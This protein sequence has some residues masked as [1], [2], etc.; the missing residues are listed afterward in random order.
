MAHRATPMLFA[1]GFASMGSTAGFGGFPDPGGRNG[2]V[3]SSGGGVRGGTSISEAARLGVAVTRF[4]PC[5]PF[6]LRARSN[7]ASGFP[8]FAFEPTLTYDDAHRRFSS[9][10]SLASATSSGAAKHVRE[11]LDSSSPRPCLCPFRGCFCMNAHTLLGPLFSS[12][13]ATM[14]LFGPAPGPA[15]ARWQGSA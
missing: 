8:A 11:V 13:L 3:E 1:N 4:S 10:P 14:D 6:S 2:L 5:R 7:G 15:A 9:P 12:C